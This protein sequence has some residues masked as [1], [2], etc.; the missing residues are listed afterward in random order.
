VNNKRYKKGELVSVQKGKVNA[1]KNG[2]KI[3]ISKEEYYKGGYTCNNTNKKPVKDKYGRCFLINKNSL[4]SKKYKHVSLGLVTAINKSTGKIT[5][6]TT[7]TFKKNKNYVG[8][9]YK[10]FNGKNN[11]NAKIIKIYDNKN[12][13][14]ITCYGNFKKICKKRGYPFV[15]L[16]KSYYRKGAPIYKNLK[17]AKE[18]KRY[19]GWYAI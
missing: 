14:I 18:H 19:I 12:K 11:P 9:N 6:V 8:I 3:L 15:T 7:N 1:I 17:Y 16:Q 10:K 5:K 2:K 13:L 4:S